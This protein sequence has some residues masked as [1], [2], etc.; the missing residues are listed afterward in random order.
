[1]HDS[2]FVVHAPDGIASGQ[3]ADE[4]VEPMLLVL[5]DSEPEDPELPLPVLPELALPLL[6]EPDVVLLAEPELSLAVVEVDVLLSEADVAVPPL[7]CDGDVVAVALPTDVLWWELLVVE[8]VLPVLDPASSVIERVV[9]PHATAAKRE[10]ERAP[11]ERV[12]GRVGMITSSV[13]GHP[14]PS[15]PRIVT[16]VPCLCAPRARRSAR[17]RSPDRAR[18]TRVARPAALP[19]CPRDDD[20]R[21]CPP[22]SQQRHSTLPEA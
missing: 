5:E 4:L 3:L 21:A 15:Q 11:R 10:K 16:P 18:L 1:M 8:A 13:A 17:P 7:L 22:S 9:P 12:N 20:A 6:P 14:L 2:P 19:S